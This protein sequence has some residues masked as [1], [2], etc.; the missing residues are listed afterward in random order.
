LVS[1]V[2]FFS[3]EVPMGLVRVLS[4]V[5]VCISW[6]ASTGGRGVVGM[7]CCVQTALKLMVRIG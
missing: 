1:I 5:F 4:F 2:F 7:S 6:S 3:C